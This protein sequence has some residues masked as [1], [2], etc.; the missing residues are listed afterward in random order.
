VTFLQNV[1]F[2]IKDKRLCYDVVSTVDGLRSEV[3]KLCMAD[4]KL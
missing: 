1:L 2:F 3:A 4:A